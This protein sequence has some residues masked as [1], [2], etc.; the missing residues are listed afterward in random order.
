[1]RRQY[2]PNHDIN[3]AMPPRILASLCYFLPVMAAAFLLGVL[4]VTFLVPALGSDFAA[5]ALELPIILLISWR[6]TGPV[7]RHF[8]PISTVGAMVIGAT[9]FTMLIASELLL[10]QMLGGQSAAEWAR[11]IGTAAGLLGLAGQ[12]LFACIPAIRNRWFPPLGG[13]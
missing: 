10:A 6:V 1:M 7:L 8:G 13:H 9:A 11:E 4:R 2:S 3:Q 5:V 12:L